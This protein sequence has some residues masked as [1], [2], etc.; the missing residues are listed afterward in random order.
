MSVKQH[1]ATSLVQLRLLQQHSNYSDGVVIVRSKIIVKNFQ[2]RTQN[3]RA[4]STRL[5]NAARKRSA[6]VESGN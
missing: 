2:A 6:C 3:A 4:F 1:T 5:A